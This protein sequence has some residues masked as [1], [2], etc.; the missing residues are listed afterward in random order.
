MASIGAGHAIG[1]VLRNAA[2]DRLHLFALPERAR[3]WH[4]S[5]RR[6]LYRYGEGHWCLV[7]DQ[8]EW[9][10][11]PHS[12]LPSLRDLSAYLEQYAYDALEC[13]RLP[14]TAEQSTM[15]TSGHSFS[16]TLGWSGP[17]APSA[18][19]SEP[20]RYSTFRTGSFDE[21]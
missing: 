21:W 18:L 6:L 1:S 16:M 8:N 14:T 19:S 5:L 9:L 2:P 13:R 15:K 4:L 10:L 20:I 11:A 12:T 3:D 17:L 7:L